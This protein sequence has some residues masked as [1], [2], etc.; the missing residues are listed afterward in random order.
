MS[1]TG[2][3]WRCLLAEFGPWT[4][5]W[6]QF[7]RWSRNGTWARLL[8]ELHRAVRV[9]ANRADPTPSMIVVDTHLARG[10]PTR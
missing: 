8:A 10:A 7:R 1:R 9:K 5:V 2:C 4:R 3:Q 6:S